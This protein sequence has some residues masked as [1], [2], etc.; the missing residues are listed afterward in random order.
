MEQKNENYKELMDK[1]DYN[2]YLL[3]VNS[4]L[5]RRQP[6]QFQVLRSQ[7]RDKTPSL[8][9]IRNP[10]NQENAN[11]ISYPN[12][13]SNIFIQNNNYQRG[14]NNYR[15]ISSN[16]QYKEECDPSQITNISNNTLFNNVM[17]KNKNMNIL[18]NSNDPNNHSLNYTMRDSN[19]SN[20]SGS[21]FTALTYN[22]L[23]SKYNYY[24]VLFHQLKGHNLA[25][26]NQIK[27]DK[28]L[29][30]VIEALEKEN[31]R[32]KNEN[33]KLKENS[34]CHANSEGEGDNRSNIRNKKKFGKSGKDTDINYVLL[35]E[36]NILK[37]EIKKI[38]KSNKKKSNENRD[39]EESFEN[40]ES[41]NENIDNN[42]MLKMNSK[43]I[44]EYLNNLKNDKK[45]IQKFNKNEL[46]SIVENLQNTN[47]DQRNELINLYNKL[48]SQDDENA[49][50]NNDLNQKSND[51]KKKELP[52]LIDNL[53]VKNKN[54]VEDIKNKGIKEKELQKQINDLI[55]KNKLLEDDIKNKEKHESELLNQINNLTI[56]N[57]ILKGSIN[58]KEQNENETKEKDLEMKLEELLSEKKNLIENVNNYELN[59][60]ELQKQ[61]ND[62][63]QEN[64]N[65]KETINKENGINNNLFENYQFD[66]N[67]LNQQN[68]NIIN[69]VDNKLKINN[70]N[71]NLEGNNNIM[72]DKTDFIIKQIS[73]SDEPKIEIEKFNKKELIAIV[74]RL[75]NQN[76]VQENEL[77]N[78]NNKIIEQ[79]NNIKIIQNN[80]EEKENDLKKQI[81]ELMIEKQTLEE[82]INQMNNDNLNLENQNNKNNGSDDEY[83]DA[84]NEQI[85]NESEKKEGKLNVIQNN[86]FEIEKMNELEKKEKEIE[87]KMK[88]ID[89]KEKII[90]IEKKEIEESKLEIT[91]KENEIGEKIKKYETINNILENKEIDENEFK[92]ILEQ[93]GITIKSNEKDN[94]KEQEINEK[95]KK[96]EELELKL[97]R[98]EKELEVK[99]LE[100]E[101]K[102]KD[103]EIKEKTIENKNIEIEIKEKELENKKIEI[104]IKE[105]EIENKNNEK[106]KELEIKEKNIENNLN[107]LELKMKNNEGNEKILQQKNNVENEYNSLKIKYDELEQK[108]QA[109]IK[110]Q[111]QEINDYKTKNYQLEQN[112]SELEKTI[113]ELQEKSKNL[114]D[115][116]SITFNLE[117]RK[118]GLL[119]E[120]TRLENNKK[121]L[122]QKCEDLKG[123]SNLSVDDLQSKIIS[124]KEVN[125]LLYKQLQEADRQ[126]LEFESKLIKLQTAF[127]D[128]LEEEKREIMRLYKNKKM[129]ENREA[130]F[131]S[132]GEEGNNI[133]PNLD[134]TKKDEENK[135]DEKEND[136]D[137]GK[138]KELKESLNRMSLLR[139]ENKSLKEVV[140]D[141]K[142]EIIELKNKNTLA[143]KGYNLIGASVGG[144]KVDENSEKIIE[145]LMIECNKWKK[146]YST[147]YNENNVLKKYVS[148]LEKN[149]G[150]EDQMNNLR[151]LLAEKDQL[152]INLSQQIKA[153][154]TKCDD[155]IIGKSEESKDRQIQRLLNEVK[156]VRKRIL[157]IITL[158]DRITNF[159]EF[160]EALKCIKQLEIKNKDKNIEKAFDQLT[161]LMDI[162]QQNDDKA[163]SKF[164]NE[165]YGEGTSVNNL[166][167]FDNFNNID[168]ENQEKNNNFV[169]FGNNNQENN[170]NNNYNGGNNNDENNF[171]NNYFNTDMNN[172]N[173]K[174][175]NNDMD[176]NTNNNRNNSINNNNNFDNNNNNFINNFNNN[177]FIGNNNGNENEDIN[178]END[179]DDINFDYFDNDNNEQN[180]I[181][182]H[183]NENNNNQNQDNNQNN[184]ND[185]DFDDML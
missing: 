125:D 27:K 149:L 185:D 85:V 100:I 21:A 133:M 74:E 145:E 70:I 144:N 87:E 37:N 29:N 134:E 16:R 49:E 53:L 99:K 152:L 115:L 59:L 151:T 60:K 30:E 137:K 139:N 158:N 181:N 23:N 19:Y 156:G 10:I 36:N 6:K 84:I 34:E 155:I 176:F 141:L 106:Q 72:I 43:Q 81:E 120:N 77:S 178:D 117:K 13:N 109:L 171:N 14:R 78:L 122:E 114:E 180:N 97:D 179:F 9:R 67:L 94:S 157:S 169:N 101:E 40:Y 168:N 175:N 76:I 65:L 54:L 98:K 52:N 61:I 121:I 167:N 88:D 142:K 105:K 4:N 26:L 57:D 68:K 172:I 162:Y 33:Q 86:G 56:N 28:N 136:K 69:T 161:Y 58:V 48:I 2:N 95:I 51:A 62:L 20:F 132:G 103:L 146:E 124:M 126:K 174:Q 3:N 159:N 104:D 107:E 18:N 138:P 17:D 35:E 64:K 79:D 93:N 41:L 130:S 15:F 154:Q 90:E 47:E 116:Q 46:I 66:E 11:N 110:E 123:L 73:K 131:L 135:G 108:N 24:K 164:V 160:I 148:K 119:E 184:N 147:M 1:I 96:N 25:L 44:S 182:Q 12:I 45:E 82:N 92:N 113:K 143:N 112:I 80:N 71:D 165:I 75:L 89:E 32:L 22:D 166:I 91:N 83:E 173:N 63:T 31:L 127:N 7:N 163:Y 39:I 118:S 8:T 150:V 177:N 128:Q 55:E 50:R 42:K 129:K 102:E 170:F 111:S 5:K 38:F 183:N 140:K 153:Y